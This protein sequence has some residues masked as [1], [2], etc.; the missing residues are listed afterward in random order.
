MSKITFGTAIIFS[1]TMSCFYGLSVTAGSAVPIVNGEFENGKT[2]WWGEGGFS[3]VGEGAAEGK[4]CLKLAGG[5]A[6]QDKIKIEGGKKYKISMKIKSDGAPEG[7]VFVQMSYRG[8]GFEAKWYGPSKANGEAAL[9]STG[10]THD[11]KDFSVVVKSPKNANQLLIYLRKAGGSAGIAYYDDVKAEETNDEVTG[12]VKTAGGVPGKIVNN[13]NFENGKAA[14]W[15]EGDF[16]ISAEGSAEGKNCMK[17]TGGF[18]CQDKMPVDEGKKYLISMKIKSEGA[19]ERSIYVQ[20]SYRGEGLSPG[21]SGPDRIKNEA[22]LFVTGGTHD[23]K[24]FS[25]VVKAPNGADQLLVYLRKLPKSDGTAYYDDVKVEETDKEVTTAAKLRRD[26]FAKEILTQP[27]PDG[28]AEAALNKIAADA[29]SKTVK[30]VQLAEAGKPACHIHVGY[31]EG[32]IELSAAAEL[33]DYLKKISGADFK[34][35][36]ND[37]NPLADLPLII[38][39]RHNKLTEKLCPDIPYDKLGADGFVIRTVGQNIV[40]AGATPRGTMYGVYWFLEKNLGVKWFAP[41]CEKVPTNASLSV[42]AMNEEKIPRFAY[43]EFFSREAHNDKYAAHNLL[44]GR[45]HGRAYS[46]SAPEIDDWESW[47]HGKQGSATFW[48]L[49]PDKKYHTGGQISMMNEEV[50][51]ITAESIISRLKKLDDYRSQVFNLHDLDWGWQMDTESK[52][53]ADKHG[54]NPSAPRLDMAIDVAN[55]VRKVLPEAKISF[56][57]YH[58]SFTPPTGMTVPDYV[59]VYPMTIHVDYSSPL[60]KGPNEKLGQD[61]EGWCK[62]S[63]KVLVWD[64]TIN[65]LGYIQPT[66]N[67]YPICESIQWLGT[68]GPVMG[69]FAEDSWETEGAEFAAMRTWVA[70]K[71]LWDPKQDYKALIK[72]FAEGYYGKAAP[73]MLKYI[74]LMHESITKTKDPLR[75]KTTPTGAYLSF[76][77]LNAADK[78]FEDARKAVADDPL[79]LKHVDTTSMSVDYVIL[80]RRANFAEDAKTA[81]IQWSPDTEKR[82]ERL[83]KNYE[84]AKMSCFFQ[85]GKLDDLKAMVSVERRKPSAPDIAKDLPATDWVEFQDLYCNRYMAQVVSDEVASDGGAV[86]LPGKPHIWGIQFRPANL[87]KEGKWDVWAA[88]RV[89]KNKG[90]DGDDALR[91]GFDPGKSASIKIGDLTEGSYK[92]VKFPGGPYIYDSGD[93]TGITTFYFSNTG[94]DNVKYLY[95]DRIVAI[96]SK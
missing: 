47:W 63:K 16:A 78:L 53:F 74:E 90:G 61:I 2:S 48:E 46:P 60:N 96:R 59:L 55:R 44:N 7:S 80:L 18:A 50:R 17:L 3:I 43:R 8:E 77:F 68:L 20:I 35:L 56:N 88:V 39:G 27:G 13:G 10:G 62:I 22:A 93:K 1:M 73:Y 82:K 79:A 12:A 67:L 51:R 95:V 36:S 29:S 30:S 23:W 34:P 26:A 86:R 81:G 6:C 42:P 66:P 92:W 84:Q 57:A 33:A 49:V 69:Y 76:E 83:F 71:L 72:E 9:F 87:P 89:D 40:I 52:A 85:G 21:W 4:S 64:H 32:L 28:T 45:S 41:D 75:E 58:W 5:F 54:G 24:E 38:V 31:D 94:N 14:W 25:A 70:A 65:F 19:P 11:W 91:L 37:R 15:G